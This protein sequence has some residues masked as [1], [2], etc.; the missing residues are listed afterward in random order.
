MNEQIMKLNNLKLTN[1][2]IMGLMFFSLVFSFIPSEVIAATT[3]TDFKDLYDWIY[4]AATGYLGR[5]IAI[6]GGLIGLGYGAASG[7]AIPAIVGIV[8]AIFGALGPKIIDSIFK[9]AIIM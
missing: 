9:S 1:N 8:L 7:K 3:G 5:G 6:T 2:Q 4:G